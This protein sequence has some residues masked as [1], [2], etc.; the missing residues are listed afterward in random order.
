MPWKKWA[1]FVILLYPAAAAFANPSSFPLDPRMWL[2]VIILC[3][4]LG[5]EVCVVTLILFFCHMAAVPTL[6]ALFIGNLVMYFVI[7]APLLSAIHNVWVAE[8]LIIA[9]EGI[10]IKKISTIDTFQAE[11]FK[12]LKWQTAIIVSAVGNA[13]SY[14]VG[15]LAGGKL[16]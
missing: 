9:V 4:I 6:I 10:F 15:T 13:L 1:V 3:A 7:F 16:V 5:I 11:D 8:L 14:Y 2:A 12:G